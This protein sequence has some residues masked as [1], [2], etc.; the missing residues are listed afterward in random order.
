MQL[1]EIAAISG[2]GGLYRIMKP[3][4]STVVLEALDETKAKMVAGI[5]HRVSVLHEISIYTTSKEGTE[6]LQEVLKKIHEK[7]GATLAVDPDGDPAKLREFLKSV[8][9]DYDEQRVYTSD[10]KKLVKW[11]SIIAK[12]AP[13]IL[14]AEQPAAK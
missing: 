3:G 8:L 7:H 4:K 12:F 2:K 14:T 11:Y 5:K 10:I 9:P 13:E 1:S 6:S